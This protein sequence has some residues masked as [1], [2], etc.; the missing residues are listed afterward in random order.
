MV[1]VFLISEETAPFPAMVVLTDVPTST[2]QML[3]FLHSTC[4]LLLLSEGKGHLI[5]VYIRS[6]LMIS[7]GKHFQSIL[8]HLYVFFWKMSI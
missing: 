1:I 5:V 4:H 7:D 8:G 2:V 3:P 6:F